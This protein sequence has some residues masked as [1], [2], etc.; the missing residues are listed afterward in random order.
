MKTPA[1]INSPYSASACGIFKTQAQP[2]LGSLPKRPAL[3]PIADAAEG[4]D[5]APGRPISNVAGNIRANQMYQVI[6]VPKFCAGSRVT[7]DAGN[8]NQPEDYLSRDNKVELEFPAF[9]YPL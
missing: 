3:H 1:E 9:Q 4:T 2:V 5:Q 8:N 6:A 7:E